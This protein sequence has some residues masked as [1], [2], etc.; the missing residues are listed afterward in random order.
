MYG[1][2]LNE[3]SIPINIQIINCK[4]MSNLK[5]DSEGKK[6][7]DQLDPEHI[8]KIILKCMKKIS[9]LKMYIMQT[10]HL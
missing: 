5:K 6:T 3:T 1:L 7:K 9:G 10:K 4:V 8:E 2:G